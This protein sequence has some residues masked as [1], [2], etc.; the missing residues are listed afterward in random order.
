[1]LENAAMLD[2]TLSDDDIAT[3]DALTTL[4]NQ[5]DYVKLHCKCV[6]CDTTKNAMPCQYK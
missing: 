2:L 6:N 3:L 4:E 1:M 5:Q